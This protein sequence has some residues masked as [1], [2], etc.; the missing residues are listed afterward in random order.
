ME[1]D[2][3]A[4]DELEKLSFIVGQWE[5]EGWMMGRD[6]T[7]H[8]FTQTEN[9]QY[10]LDNTAILIEGIGTSGGQ[11][12]HNALAVV[13]FNHED[14]D[15]T[16]NSYLATGQ[17]GEFKGEIMDGKFYWFP[18]ENMRYIIELNED[19]HWL[20]VGEINQNGSWFQFFEMRLEKV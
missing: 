8:T 17:T 9:V 20:E 11:I 1:V 18:N 10:K 7:K 5:G 3:K 4:Q 6:G 2:K 14:A 13:R 15:Y 16:F 12:I 19:G